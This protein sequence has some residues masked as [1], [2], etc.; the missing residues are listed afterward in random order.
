MNEKT[1]T[2]F[3]L[4]DQTRKQ[5]KILA[6]ETNDKQYAIIENLIQQKFNEHK[7]NTNKF[8]GCPS[9]GSVEESSK[10]TNLG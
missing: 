4:N 2:C 7:D 9:W 8:R 5:L 6:A 10:M 3:R 1:M